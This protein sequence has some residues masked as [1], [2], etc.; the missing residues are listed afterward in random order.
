M[1][2]NELKT[3]FG[4]FIDSVNE[5][6]N[7][8]PKNIIL[9]RKY[10]DFNEDKIG[11]NAPIRTK[12]LEFIDSKGSVSREELDEFMNNIKEEK[13]KKPNW[14]WVRKNSSLIDKSVNEETGI[15]YS[16]TKRGKRVLE[17]YRKFE[18]FVSSYKSKDDAIEEDSN[19]DLDN[20]DNIDNNDQ[21]NILADKDADL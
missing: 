4:D 11:I 21:N 19:L 18:E 9:K 12:V 1:A 3:N 17:A 16:L 15:S 13:G 2:L 6:V 14:G 5:D 20:I 7:F 8:I 10:R